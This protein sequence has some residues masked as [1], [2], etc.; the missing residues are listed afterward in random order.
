MQ[1]TT[2]IITQLPDGTFQVM[3]SYDLTAP[4]GTAYTN[5]SYD[6]VTQ[7]AIDS[8]VATAQAQLDSVQTL[9]T[10]IQTAVSAKLSTLKVIK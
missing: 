10:N 3:K 5:Y 1:E 8:Q 6:V 7:D 9:Q 4:D 2:K